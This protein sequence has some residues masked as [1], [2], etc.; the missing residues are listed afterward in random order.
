MIH[1]QY[2]LTQNRPNKVQAKWQEPSQNRHQLDVNIRPQDFFSSKC[3]REIWRIHSRSLEKLLKEESQQPILLTTEVCTW[4]GERLNSWK[5]SPQKQ[6][7]KKQRLQL[8]DCM[9]RFHPLRTLHLK[10]NDKYH[11]SYVKRYR[12]ASKFTTQQVAKR[13]KSFNCRAPTPS[14]VVIF[15]SP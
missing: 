13:S 7:Q 1:E 6:S 3:W 9:L 12:I 15:S 14:L 11:N 8:G 10:T 5:T 2:N 4:N